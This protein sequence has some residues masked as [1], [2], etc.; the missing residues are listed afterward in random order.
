MKKLLCTFLIFS[1]TVF[2]IIFSVNAQTKSAKPVIY[3]AELS[4]YSYPFP[5]KYMALKLENIPCKMA[6][7][8]VAASGKKE[9]KPVVLLLHGKNFFGAYWQQTVRFLTAK[10]YRV[11]VPDQIGF[12]KST[13]APLHYSFHQLAWNTKKLLDTL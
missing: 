7:M 11:L 3:D 10:G 13:K 4:Q 12:G 2:G 6:Y 5:V 1:A 9:N 8:D